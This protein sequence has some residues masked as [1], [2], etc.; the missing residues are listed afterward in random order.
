ME[1][2]FGDMEESFRALHPY[3][4][5]DWLRGNRGDIKDVTYKKR[6]DILSSFFN[7]CVKEAYLEFSPIDRRWYPRLPQ[8]VPTF[9]DMDDT[10]S[11]GREG[12]GLRN[13]AII[14]LMLTS[15]CNIREVYRLNIAEVDFDNRTVGVL[16][17]GKKV[18]HV[19]L[20]E[21]CLVL[22]ER[23]LET[24]DGITT[25]PLFVSTRKKMRLRKEML[26]MIVSVFVEMAGQ[27]MLLPLYRLRR[28]YNPLLLVKTINE[29]ISFIS[30][31]RVPSSVE[32]LQN[33]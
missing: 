5:L 32:E 17:K 29:P 24:R 26:Y 16:G 6:L 8:Y 15:G 4:I 7:F 3:K 10:V 21:K 18:R 31:E 22:L 30:L 1:W 33:Y 12:S 25:S 14:E 9:L 20:S 2:F 11:K 23:Y 27:S 13:Q 28:S 19:P